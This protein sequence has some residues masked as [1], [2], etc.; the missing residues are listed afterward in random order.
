M[1]EYCTYG[2]PPTQQGII[3]RL[4]PQK[5]SCFICSIVTQ[6]INGTIVAMKCQLSLK[7]E[8]IAMIKLILPLT[9]NKQTVNNMNMNSI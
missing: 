3:L 4:K 9:C 5:C 7:Q 2:I 6:L 8:L 1:V